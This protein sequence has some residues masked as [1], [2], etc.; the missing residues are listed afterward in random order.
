MRLLGTA[1]SAAPP[2]HIQ[3]AKLAA[4]RL[5][6]PH[7]GLYGASEDP[8]SREGGRFWPTGAVPPRLHKINTDEKADEKAIA[9]HLARPLR[10][11][12]INRML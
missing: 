12:R 10:D 4:A 2:H 11:L 5:L 9:V 1:S 7:R 6:S 3:A 8:R